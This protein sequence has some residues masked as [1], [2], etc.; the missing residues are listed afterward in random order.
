MVPSFPDYI[1][2][3]YST[4][5]YEKLSLVSKPGTWE[6][7]WISVIIAVAIAHH[8]NVAE[9]PVSINASIAHQQYVLKSLCERRF[10]VNQIASLLSG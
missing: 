4:N 3:V 7:G 10:D 6:C 1:L 2:V 9:L 8:Q 5:E